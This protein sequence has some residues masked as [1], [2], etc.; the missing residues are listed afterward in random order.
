MN[1]KYTLWFTIIILLCTLSSWSQ[2][3]SNYTFST[4]TDASLTDMSTGTTQLVAPNIDG[5]GQGIFSN[6]NDL[7]FTFYFMSVPYTTFVVTEDGVIRLGTSLSAIVRVPGTDREYDD[8]LGWQ[9]LNEP[10]I[11][12]FSCDMRTGSNGK[13]H[14]KV[15]GAAPNRVLIIEWLN[16]QIPYPNSGTTGNSTFQ[17]R[18]YETTGKIE[19]VYGYMYVGIH[20]GGQEDFGAI[21]IGHGNTLDKILTKSGAFS[22][23]NVLN[24]VTSYCI[25][26]ALITAA[27]EISGLSSS[28]DGARRIYTF[29]PRIAPD[30]PTNLTFSGITQ[31][32]MTLNW[33]DNSN[34][35]TQFIIYRSDDG[36][37]TYDM[38]GTSPANSTSFGPI[39]GLPDKAY[40]W[41]I[42]AV[43]EGAC[44]SALEGTCSTL[45]AGVIYSTNAGGLWSLP[46]TWQGGVLPTANDNVI[47][48][49]GATVTI[50]IIT[51]VC[52]NLQIG[53]GASGILR[54]IGGV[55]NATLTTDGDI[56]VSS[57]GT[58]DITNGATGGARKII[59]GN[60]AYANG[61]L[62]VNGTFDMNCAGANSIADVEFRGTVD[63]IISGTGATCDFY[64]I[65][66]NKGTSSDNVLDVTRIITM[67]TPAVAANRLVITNGTFKLSSASNLIPYYGAQTICA[68]TSKL[69]LN[70]NAAYVACVGT[71]TASGAGNVTINGILKVTSGIFE[72]GSGNNSMTVNGTLEIDGNNAVVNMYGNVAFSN[73]A[74][75][76]SFFLMSAGAFN[77]D[78]QAANNLGAS[79][80]CLFESNTFVNFTGGILTIIDPNVNNN[81][82]FRVAGSVTKTFNSSTIRFGNGASSSAG[83]A[84]STGFSLDIPNNS[85]RLGDIVVNNPA[86]ANRNVSIVSTDC[87]LENL[88]IIAGS[89][90]IN[91]KNL[92]HWGNLTNNGNL[93][94]NAASSS[95]RFEGT[96]P[97]AYS[98][99]TG[100]VTNAANLLFEI[101]N[102]TGVTLNSPISTQT[103]NLIEGILNTTNTNIITVLGN[104]A[105]NVTVT[106]GIT[107]TYVN[108]PMI[109]T[110]ATG[111]GPFLFPVGKS[112]YNL[113]ELITLAAATPITLQVEAFDT[114]CGGTIAA[115]YQL[116]TNRYWKAN[117]TAGTLTSTSVRI[118]ESAP[119][120]N[121]HIGNCATING[122]Y[123][124]IFSSQAGNTLTTVAT[125]SSLNF[126]CVAAPAFL[127]GTYELGTGK[128]FTSLTQN[129]ATGFFNALNKAGLKGNVVLKVTSDI[130]EDGAISLNQWAE[131]NGS[132]YTINIIPDGTTL[133]TFTGTVGGAGATPPMININ[134]ADRFKIDGVNYYLTFRNTRATAAQTGAVIQLTNSSN[135]C[136]IANSILESNSSAAASGVLV[137][138]NTGTNNNDT[139]SGNQI[140]NAIAGTVGSPAN[141]IYSNF[142]T[143][144]NLNVINNQIYNWTGNGILFTL[145]G[146]N[147]IISGNHFYNNLAVSPSTQQ[148]SIN[149]GSGTNHLISNNFIGGQNINC[150]GASPWGNSGN[151]AFKGIVVTSGIGLPVSIQGNT[152]QNIKLTGATSAFTGIEILSGP[153]NIGTVTGNT[154]GHASTANSIQ[155][156]GNTV[157]SAI[158]NNSVSSVSI[159]NNT[160]ANILC[161]VANTTNTFFG[162]WHANTGSGNIS[163]NIIYNLSSASTRTS[164]S[165]MG[166]IGIYHSGAS[167]GS[168]FITENT[169][170]NLSLT[171]NGNVQTNVSGICVT[172]VS[173]PIINR[174]V[175]YDLRNAAI[176][177][178]N[179]ATNP[180][181]ASGIV[182][183]RPAAAST[184]EVRTNMISLGTGAATNT[185]FNGI[186]LNSGTNAYTA[187]VYYNSVS[188]NG[189]VGAGA[190][191]S[192]GLLRGDNNTVASFGNISVSFRNN[193]F[194]N[195][196]SGGTGKHYAIGNQGNTPTVGWGATST[197]YNFYVSADANNIGLWNITS[198]PISTWRTNT[199]GDASS[200]SAAS[201]A[202]PS[203]NSIINVAN[204][205]TDIANGDLHIK[206]N[207]PEAWYA[208]G[209]G[210][211][212]TLSSDIDGD[213][214][215]TAVST[216]PT[217]VGADE[218]DPTTDPI[219]CII[220]GPFIDG[221]NTIFYF[222]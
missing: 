134:G 102:A 116:V 54:F 58:F 136:K 201:T 35:E 3:A 97:Q 170:Y 69:W 216:G 67:N 158:K 57:G 129:N 135:D 180:P 96:V 48:K 11:V 29:T 82:E 121:L 27:G 101:N 221:N 7:G 106:A 13:V 83:N 168:S 71:G 81:T 115:P 144:T 124:D 76:T 186:W 79:N 62:T 206:S 193:I 145:I 149:I 39:N 169:I 122:L 10:R 196:R 153:S 118:T 63:G 87:Y 120:T 159:W 156:A 199:T 20:R 161:S 90:R 9:T 210:T 107:T 147:C 99:T 128:T 34:N 213:P 212:M 32:T 198:C 52:N 113:F 175:I 191:P 217:D 95:I 18:L 17:V 40:F 73:T 174:N 26:P 184:V 36:G 108:G 109:R 55:T 160:I 43:N 200:F 179:I 19:F 127:S 92:R 4:A 141:G 192:F 24:T 215:S 37:L 171:N 51:A 211:Q 64:S 126:F 173:S 45:P 133:R 208:N 98:A 15:T 154:I 33:V 197:N 157:S 178:T 195:R 41:R 142:A 140:K 163:N 112:V 70:N 44:S 181:T 21:G 38:A 205:F 125:L 219:A 1:N 188:L 123:T 72:Y 46:A 91:G 77:I 61:N 42:Y 119:T 93:N 56:T 30:A 12:P 85:F 78:P 203:D 74:A 66:V 105:T 16:L 162:I 89:F 5:V 132:G 218:F 86:G 194:I 14:Y 117:I 164:L 139:I 137:I 172:G 207:Q 88:N 47:I 143:N 165:D 23:A 25:L 176:K 167:V 6:V 130:T 65:N 110:C 222:C 150:G 189:N 131:I 50:D 177:T 214:R 28:T 182:V 53:Q 155:L 60:R 100:T 148:Y 84:T 202:L 209:K 59:I 152:I 31:T 114:D 138:G 187:S 8:I 103:L 111:A 49:D 185:E 183:Y 151:V 2:N 220:S 146:D 94:A 204:F 104:A 22:N 68:A 75:P 166:L 190:L 80:V